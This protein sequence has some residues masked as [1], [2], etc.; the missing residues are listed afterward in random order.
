M[1]DRGLQS[2]C[3]TT[4][5]KEHGTGGSLFGYTRFYGEVPGG[6]AEHLRV[7]QARYGPIKVPEGAPECSISA[8]ATTSAR[9]SGAAPQAGD[10]IR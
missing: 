3:E 9:R 7:P 4:Q 2:Q 8:I 1:C 6:Q 5:V 10:R